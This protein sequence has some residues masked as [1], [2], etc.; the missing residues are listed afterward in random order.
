MCSLIH[1][2]LV[3]GGTIVWKTTI[4]EFMVWS[5]AMQKEGMVTKDNHIQFETDALM[6]VLQKVEKNPLIVVKSVSRAGSTQ[7]RWNAMTTSA[8]YYVVAHR[9]GD[10]DWYYEKTPLGA[11]DNEYPGSCNTMLGIKPPIR[12]AKLKDSKGHIARPQVSYTQR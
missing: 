9:K 7:A 1:K 11:L 5:E 8:Y 4:Q 10:M 6:F 2:L 12:S 3:G